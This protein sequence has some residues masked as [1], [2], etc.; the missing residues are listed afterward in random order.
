MMGDREKFH[1]RGSHA[2]PERRSE[3]Y[4]K[5]VAFLDRQLATL[6]AEERSPEA[7]GYRDVE[8]GELLNALVYMRRLCS[9]GE[10]R[11]SWVRDTAR[12]LTEAAAIVTGKLDALIA[13]R[14]AGQ[15]PLP[16]VSVGA[17]QTIRDEL[18]EVMQPARD[19]SEKRRGARAA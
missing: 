14:S 11:E 10:G 5:L 16:A 15:T 19:K 8:I 1:G 9:S 17:L 4:E 2:E 12:E 18:V 3:P 13:R 7:A 6:G